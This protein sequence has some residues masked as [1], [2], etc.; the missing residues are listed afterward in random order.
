TGSAAAS[1]ASETPSPAPS[2][3]AETPAVPDATV[4]DATVPDAI[5]ADAVALAAA[6]CAGGTWQPISHDMDLFVPTAAG[7]TNCVLGQGSHNWGVVALQNVLRNCY[8]QGIALDGVFGPATRRAVMN[9][10]TWEN[11]VSSAGLA[12]DGVYGN[13]TRRAITWPVYERGANA[14]LHDWWACRYVHWS[15]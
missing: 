14:G 8:G 5:T 10:Q 4:P 9:A 3:A 15:S 1:P 7:S 12:V 11:A 13:S 6:S 2:P